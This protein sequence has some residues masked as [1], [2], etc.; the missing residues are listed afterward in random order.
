MANFAV[1]SG[2][3]KGCFR[4][5]QLWLIQCAGNL[6]LFGFF[7]LWLLIPVSNAWHLTLNLLLALLILIATLALHAGTLNYFSSHDQ[8]ESVGLAGSFRSAIRNLPAIAVCA[9]VF[10]LLWFL[11]GTADRYE[12]SLPNYLRSVSPAFV[13]NLFSLSIYEGLVNAMLFILQWIV[14]PG[15]V[16]PSLASASA[17]GF[18]GMAHRGFMAWKNCVTNVFYWGVIALGAILGVY[19]TEQIMGAT[20]DF[21]TSTLAHE[22]ASVIARGVVSYF[23]AL[24]AWMLVCSMIGR[25]SGTVAHVAEN[26]AGQT[27]A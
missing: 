25:Q 21:R 14:V 18:G 24:L 8:G 17:L 15:L 27:A 4:N 26:V 16:L 10:C 23:L 19:T 13:R 3:V 1:V 5:W 6:V 7:L 12:E 9:A 20:P 22:T 11:A 2:A